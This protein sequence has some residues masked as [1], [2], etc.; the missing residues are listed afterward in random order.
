MGFFN[1][2]MGVWFLVIGLVGVLLPNFLEYTPLPVWPF[3]VLLVVG[4]GLT[5]IGIYNSLKKRVN[6][7]P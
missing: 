4:A 1:W 5:G 6:K 2:R 7:Q 3:Y